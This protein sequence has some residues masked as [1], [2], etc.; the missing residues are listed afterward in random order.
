MPKCIELLPCDWLIRNLRLMCSWT[1][2]PNKV[3]GECILAVDNNIKFTREDVRGDSLPSWT[4]LHT[5][6]KTEAVIS[7]VVGIS[8]NLRRI[9]S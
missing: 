4:V 5:L 1:G 7:Y 3:A 8:E 2:V 6:K 9:F